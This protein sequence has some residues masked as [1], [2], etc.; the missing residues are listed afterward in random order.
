MQQKDK[1]HPED[2]R[3]LVI[4]G[5]ISIVLW[6]AYTHFVLDPQKERMR[7]AQKVQQAEFLED[8]KKAGLVEKAE[9]PIEEIIADDKAQS[10]RVEI[11][12]DL[13]FGSINLVGARLDHL[14]LKNHFETV[15]REK[16]SVILFPSGTTH[17]KYIEGGWVS[18]D[19]TL[20]LPDT[21]TK[22]SLASGDVLTP[23]TPVTLRWDNGQGLVFEKTFSL[24]EDYLFNVT[25][26][27]IN[28][29]SAAVTL[30]PYSLIAQRDIPKEF[31]NRFIVHEG[32][33]A[34]VGDELQEETYG[35]MGK[36]PLFV[37]TASRGWVGLTTKDW[38]TALLPI[39]GDENQDAQNKFRMVYTQGAVKQIKDLYQ[40]DVTGPAVVAQA[41]ETAQASINIFAGAKKLDL[42]KKYEQQLNIPH[43]DLAV[44]FGIFY[45]LTRPFFAVINFFYGLVGNLGIAIILF[46]VVLRICVYPLAN[47]SF[48]SF[49]NMR[50]IAPQ[51]HDLREKYKDDKPQM[52][53]ALV[54]LYQKEKVNPMAG[55]L[56]ILVQIP[57][58]FSLFKVLSNTIEMR[59]APFFGWIQDLSA[60]DPTS[61]W[62]LFG[63]AP[64]DWSGPGFLEIG[65]W[66]ILM[67]ITMLFQRTLSPPPA[68]S[69]QAF[70]FRLLPWVMTIILAKFAAG[71]VIYWTF[72]NLFSTIQ[73]YII[74]TRMG[75]KVD[76]IGNILGRN[77]PDE[78][79]PVT[80]G[81]DSK[82]DL[83]VIEGEAEVVEDSTPKELSKPKPKK[84]KK[85]K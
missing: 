38:H 79:V 11:N 36:N 73:Q 25:K 39:Q 53:K 85:K 71:L 13:V 50:K 61:F 76:I 68:D 14:G 82:N 60:P 63:F 23:S 52:Q 62:N 81:K 43:F 37:K 64:W 16:N 83:D 42:L 67:L 31:M 9:R 33:I 21:K 55:C 41:G 56:P 75:V 74:M 15:K 8:Q 80:G 22:W 20:N 12:S 46:T 7:A 4:F 65:I 24:N 32:P 6:F 28:N 77:K 10:A 1:M 70:M 78:I 17:P 26:K 40:T 59:H 69:T 29:K 34:Y 30:Y 57:I 5:L 66:P 54:K 2:L 58:F 51:M 19:K 84:S 45:F 72:N 27:V 18:P 49:A 44:D 47:T 3:N 48:K 35:K